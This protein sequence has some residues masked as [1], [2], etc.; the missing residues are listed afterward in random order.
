MNDTDIFLIIE[1]LT[2]RLDGYCLLLFDIVR[3]AL[4]AKLA[5]KI[6]II[7]DC[8]NKNNNY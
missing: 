1:S 5:G 2:I 3:K 8:F 6:I 4:P 7:N